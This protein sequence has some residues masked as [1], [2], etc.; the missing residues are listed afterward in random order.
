[1]S[2]TVLSGYSLKSV[3]CIER[4]GMNGTHRYMNGSKSKKQYDDARYLINKQSVQ[5]VSKNEEVIERQKEYCYA[6]NVK[7]QHLQ[8]IVTL[9]FT[10]FD[11][12]AVYCRY[13][14]D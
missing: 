12:V 13:H 2:P 7:W 4:Y 14:G 6:R 3:G 9:F 10:G 8:D 5:S 11:D 1:M